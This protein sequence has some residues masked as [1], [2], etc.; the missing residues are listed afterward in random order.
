[1]LAGG[2]G[3]AGE[4]QQG[5]WAQAVEPGTAAGGCCGMP[6]PPSGGRSPA[7]AGQ[8]PTQGQAPAPKPLEERTPSAETLLS[9][10]QGRGEGRGCSRPRG[11]RRGP[12]CRHHGHL[13]PSDPRA[14]SATGRPAR[15]S[16]PPSWAPAPR[17]RV[18]HSRS[19]SVPAP[20]PRYVSM[21]HDPSA[22]C[23][24]LQHPQAPSP[25]PDVPVTASSC[26]RCSVH[27]SPQCHAF[28]C[29]GRHRGNAHAE[30]GRE[31]PAAR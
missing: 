26:P 1:M 10:A 9:A 8:A 17:G 28:L 14:P 27:R 25:C 19:C 5:E 23:P 21:P 31:G 30:R 16:F 13:C 7:A 6:S 20:C 3:A 12:A 2:R 11:R 22:R 24:L 15:G 29:V 4:Q 18:A